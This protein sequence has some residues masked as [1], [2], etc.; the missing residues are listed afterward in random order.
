M[1]V[2]QLVGVDLKVVP[3]GLPLLSMDLQ[4]LVLDRKGVVPLANKR[5]SLF[6]LFVDQE[7]GSGQAAMARHDVLLRPDLAQAGLRT[8]HLL[9][10]GRRVVNGFN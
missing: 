6:F 1:S 2:G 7:V 9:R 10:R 4:E 8:D 5:E 3:C